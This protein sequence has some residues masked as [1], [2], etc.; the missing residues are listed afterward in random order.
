MGIASRFL[1]AEGRTR[2]NL[3][4]FDEQTRQTTELN[5]PGFTPGPALLEDF[6]RLYEDVLQETRLVVLSG[7]L[8]PGTPADFY[9]VLIEKANRKGVRVILDAD[10]EA[11]AE[12]LKAA[13]YAIK[14][15]IHELEALLDTELKSDEA[16]VSAGRKLLETGISCIIV[17]MGGDGSIIIGHEGAIRARPFPITPQSTVGA[18]DSMVAA[19]AYSLLHDLNL[20]ETARWTSAAGT[21]TASKPGSDVCDIQEVSSKLEL[22]NISKLP[23]QV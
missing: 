12:G 7:S 20:E 8:P 23:M 11:L 10:G 17:S 3:K 6:I 13:P 18:G 5:E 19:L 21:V 2:T 16:I 1:E 15:N 22:V 14:P 4:V 9:R